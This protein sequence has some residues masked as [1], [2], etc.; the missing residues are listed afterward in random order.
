M[1]FVYDF[2]KEQSS[3][4]RGVI[5]FIG[6]KAVLQDWHKCPISLLINQTKNKKTKGKKASSLCSFFTF[7]LY[8]FRISVAVAAAGGT[9]CVYFQCLFKSILL[10][11]NHRVYLTIPFAKTRSLKWITAYKRF[12]MI[13]CSIYAQCTHIFYA[14][15]LF[16]A[17]E[18]KR[19]YFFSPIFYS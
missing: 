17:C 12:I 16:V 5:H 1:M 6:P 13:F 19:E 14:Q 10:W 11:R 2:N 8:S 18:M 9:R 15:R 4:Q 7:A 3:N